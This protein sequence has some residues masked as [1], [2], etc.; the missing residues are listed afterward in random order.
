MRG[1]LPT[2]S[3]AACGIGRFT[4]D[5]L[6]LSR[7]SQ[8][9]VICLGGPIA[10]SYTSPNVG[11]GGGCRVSASEYS[12]AHGAE[13]N[14]GDHAPY[15]TYDSPQVFSHGC[16]RGGHGICI[17]DVKFCDHFDPVCSAMSLK[18]F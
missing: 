8:R 3:A 17:A 14:L 1:K 16:E 7:R 9:D 13:I 12:C 4:Y 6:I 11:G 2:V 10:P 15:L 5:E 18:K